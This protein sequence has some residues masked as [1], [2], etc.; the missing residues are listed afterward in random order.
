MLV[1]LQ[2][3]LLIAKVLR[4]PVMLHHLL[5][6]DTLRVHFPL[7]AV[8]Q[9]QLLFLEGHQHLVLLFILVPLQLL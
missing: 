2:V 3:H 5:S 9:H 8:E 7:V 6:L 1:H 4:I